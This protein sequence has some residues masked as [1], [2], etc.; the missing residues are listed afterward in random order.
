MSHVPGIK[1]LVPGTPHR[2]SPFTDHTC[3]TV[4]TSHLYFHTFDP[5]DNF[6]LVHTMRRVIIHFNDPGTA[7]FSMTDWLDAIIKTD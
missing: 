6:R 2:T 1:Y 5:F 4:S 3:L 7:A